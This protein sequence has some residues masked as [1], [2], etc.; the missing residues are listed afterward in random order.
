MTDNPETN[1]LAEHNAGQAD[2]KHWGPYLAERAW[3]TVREDYSANGTAW[4]YFPHD[5]ARSRAYRWNEDGIG[6]FCD[7]K[8]H[9]CL[10]V[11]F[12]NEHDPIIKERMFGLANAEGNHGEDVK[13]YYFFLDGT[14]THSYMRMLYKYP[15]VE[16]PYADL[17]AENGRRDQSQ[18]EYELFDAL[19]EA[20][21]ANRYFDIEIEYAKA[22]AED[23][24]CRITA[25]N[26][27]P[28]AAPI[29]I[30]P[31]LWYRNRW[32]WEKDGKREV[33]TA[34]APG[35]ASTQH[36]L[37]GDR[38]WYTRAS[39]GQQVEL[40]FTEN[41]TNTKRLFKYPNASRYVK[42]GI[43]DAI[44]TGD[45]SSVNHEQGS[46]M[47]GYAHA[48]VP[49][50]ESFTVEVRLSPKSLVT[51]FEDF[52][53]VF[54]ARIAE[55]NQFYEALHPPTLDADQQHVGRQA[56]AG[57]LW[58]KQY[59][60]YDV[61]R[62]LKGDPTQPPPPESRWQGR[63]HCWKELHNADVILMPDT[64]E[65]PWYASWDLAFHCVAMA[66]IDAEF[67]KG[68][69]RMMGHEWY[70]H[71][72]G[73]FP[74]YEWNFDDVNPPVTGWAAWRVYQIERDATG[75]GDDE[76][77]KEVFQNE[78]LNFSF[79]LNR[80][81]SSGRDIFGGG[82]LGMDNVGVFD[83]DRPLPDGGE[84]EQS[85]GTSWMALYCIT[86][87]TIAAELAKHDPFYQ[88]MATKYFEHFLYIA[89]AMT[90]IDGAGIAL[91]D[92][93]DQFFYDVISLP[94]GE[95]IPLRL[96]SM[97]GL[98]PLFAVFSPSLEKTAHLKDFLERTEWFV[99]HR[100]DLLNKVAPVTKPGEDGRKL[101]AI[102]TQ[103]RLVAVLRRMLD[104]Q[105]FLSDYG[106]RALSKYHQDHPYIFRC[107]SEVDTVRYLPAESDSIVF[108]GNSN[109]RGPI[110]FPVNY[111]IVRSLNEFSLYYGDSLQVECPTGSGQMMS[112]KQVAV[113]IVRRLKS[114]FLRDQQ[115]GH[116]AVWGDNDYFQT[117]PHWRD[118]IM[119]SEYFNGDTGAGVGASH[120][121][122]WT[123]LVVSLIYEYWEE[124]GLS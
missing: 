81:D 50:G 21:L 58:S 52:D 25:H 15:Q 32:S 54:A 85:D 77:L 109:W 118:H 119:F 124:E 69:L 121:T 22:G 87:L 123:A 111:M 80:K 39:D 56:F 94:N 49:S 115:T 100:P 101:M 55:C 120:Q 103:K 84:L 108:G 97:V 60:H 122:G 83:R 63:N 29:H 88:N 24:L 75:V 64:W 67:A 68:Q 96:H 30:L 35:T 72:N 113:E 47:A 17:V 102:L 104:P 26:R 91:W 20:F 34:S 28:D 110:W 44:V 92:S 37:L 90:N 3:G 73:Q 12:W 46:K 114:I 95:T 107:G 9:L 106:I 4:D 62:W 57:L 82:F 74:A 7:D 45:R 42:D 53:S 71:A 31:H 41:E 10:S 5:H 11:A 8:Q 117:D 93:E 76:F 23:I 99:E 98:V 18:P 33:I 78:M 6:G 16:Y 65:Y 116:R 61:W 105:E 51:P 43:N 86:M 14:P 89:H 59:Y 13:E 27:G 2:W 70:Q 38:W 19:K 66:H 48:V 36:D 79:W 112:L 1:R 40:L